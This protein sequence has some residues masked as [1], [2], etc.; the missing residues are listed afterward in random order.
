M[1]PTYMMPTKRALFES[2]D[3]ASIVNEAS[4]HLEQA[5]DGDRREQEQVVLQEGEAAGE[6]HLQQQQQERRHER[7]ERRNAKS[8]ASLPA[9]YSERISGFDR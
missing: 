9:M 6:H 4:E 1:M 7:H 5:A 2:D 3:S 8:T